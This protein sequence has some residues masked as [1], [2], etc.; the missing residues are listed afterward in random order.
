MSEVPIAA[1]MVRRLE[2][3]PAAMPVWV[4]DTL[5]TTRLAMAEF[6]MPRPNPN[7]APATAGIQAAEW[8]MPNDAVESGDEERGTG[9]LHAQVDAARQR[10]GQEAGDAEC[11]QHREHHQ[12]GCGDRLA[13][14]VAG[15]STAS[16]G[17]GAGTPTHRTSRRRAAAR[18]SS[19]S[20]RPGDASCACRPAG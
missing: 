14:P 19:G 18:S 8:K 7:A 2:F 6:E 17:I 3:M 9:E 13:E 11:D 10:P 12:A 1:P 5:C 20:R 16:A 15:R 4:R